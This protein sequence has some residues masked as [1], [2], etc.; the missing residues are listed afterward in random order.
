M[1]KP[2]RKIIPISQLLIN[3]NNPRF[4]SVENQQVAI[5]TMLNKKGSEIK[6]LAKD[7]VTN[8]LNPSKNLMVLESKNNK[9][10]TLEGNRRGY[11]HNIVK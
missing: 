5:E 11:F 7:I 3:P 4:E 1:V 8:G 6:R 10:L 9:F 2:T